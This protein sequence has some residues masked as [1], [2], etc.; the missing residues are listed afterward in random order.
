MSLDHGTGRRVWLRAGGEFVV[1]V[2]GVLVALGVDSWVSSRDDRAQEREYLARL[3]DDVRYDLAEIDY[4]SDVTAAGLAYADSLLL[5]QPGLSDP[6]WLAGAVLIAANARVP[7]LSRNTLRE[8][9]NSGRIGLVRSTEVRRALADYDRTVTEQEGYWSITGES[10]SD[11]AAARVPY[12]VV[13]ALDEACGD[14]PDDPNGRRVLTA[15]PFD[16]GGWSAE[17]LRR[18]LATENA[19]QLLTYYTNRHGRGLTILAQLSAAA[20][21]LESVL[22]GARR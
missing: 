16:L 17:A 7:D 18:D 19:R 13:A 12:H 3:L 15:C 8:M 14:M 2:L 10:F 11:W 21:T 6:E 9:I 22:E 4:V 20:H 1:I 5:H